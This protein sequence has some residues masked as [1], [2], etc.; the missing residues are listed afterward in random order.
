MIEHEITGLIAGNNRRP[1]DI[2][3]HNF[4]EPGAVPFDVTVVSPTCATHVTTAQIAGALANAADDEK[5]RSYRG[6]KLNPLS[7]ESHG[8]P[9]RSSRWF[10]H[11]LADRMA[12]MTYDLKLDE[13]AI[14]TQRLY[15]AQKISIALQV[16]NARMLLLCGNHRAARQADNHNPD[17]L[18][19]MVD[20]RFVERRAIMSA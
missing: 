6:T 12:D 1:G 11:R 15:I 7:F 10:M 3:V 16:G 18:G 17:E 9:S 5:R 2:V 8:C 19:P 13:L 20:L 4:T 14:M